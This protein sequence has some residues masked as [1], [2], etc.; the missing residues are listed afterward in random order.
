V[1]DHDHQRLA[2]AQSLVKDPY[3]LDRTD[4]L[5]NAE[6]MSGNRDGAVEVRA[7]RA[8][9]ESEFRLVCV[10]FDQGM[11][12]LPVEVFHHRFQA[13]IGRPDYCI[14]I[15]VAGGPAVGYALAQ[16]YGPNLRLRF[17]IGRVHDLYVA[18]DLRRR[19]IGRML[20]EFVFA[21][22]SSRPEPMIL[23]WQASPRAVAFYQALGFEAD[24]IGDYADYPGFSLDLRHPS[25]DTR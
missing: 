18:P 4:A 12:D 25:V 11:D 19:G 2:L 20:M 24:R 17:T 3:S 22:A 8:D 9:D 23:D 10:G 14:A 5:C 15:A 6:A 7:A 21:W 13:L 16:D 1:E